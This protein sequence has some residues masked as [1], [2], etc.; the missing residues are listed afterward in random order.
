MGSAFGKFKYDIGDSITSFDR[1]IRII[2]RQYRESEKHKNGIPYIN[3]EKWYQY[4]CNCCGNEDWII[5]YSLDDYAHSGCNACCRPPKKIVKGINDIS[6]TAPWMLQYFIDID[7]AYTNSKYS[8]KCV[9]MKCPDCGRI[10]NKQ[11]HQVMSNGSLCCTCGDGKS[12][13]NKFMYSVLEQ[14]GIEFEYEKSFDWSGN[15]VYD[16]YFNYNGTSVV[17][18]LNGNQHYHKAINKGNRYRT[19]EQ[20]QQNDY[21]KRNVAIQNGI[22]LYYM[23]DCCESDMDYIKNSIVKSGMMDDLFLD[24]S[25]IDW[26]RCE[27]FARKNLVKSV[28]DYKENHEDMI[29]EE[30]AGLFHISRMSALRYVKIGTKLGW[31]SYCANE[32]RQ[33]KDSRRSINHGAKPVLCITTGDRFASAG[34]ASKYYQTDDDKWNPRALRKSIERNQ[35]YKGYKFVFAN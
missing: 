24:S 27:E 21:Y 33:K 11:I 16:I 10:V 12:Y 1:D 20:E 31:C 2:N 5:E 19:V 9:K 15:R 17:V 25:I 29:L 32:D 23:I 7:D 8:K 22:D 3:N 26:N 30:I 14:L 34:D 4:H 6:T 28:C 35:R 18:E 13:P